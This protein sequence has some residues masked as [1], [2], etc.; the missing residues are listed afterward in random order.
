M[1]HLP[2]ALFLAA[3]VLVSPR[4][5]PDTTAPQI[6]TTPAWCGDPCQREVYEF[7]GR[8][9]EGDDLAAI[10]VSLDGT[11]VDTRVYDDGDGFEPY[12]WYQPKWADYLEQ[13]DYAVQVPVPSGVHTVTVVLTDRAG[14]RAEHSHVVEGAAP[15]D[16]VGDLRAVVRGDRVRVLFDPA[17]DNGGAVTAYRV[18]LDGRPYAT[19]RT[20]P[21]MPLPQIVVDD[22]AAGRHRLAVRAVNSAGA[23][24]PA[25][26]RV[27][28]RR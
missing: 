8:L 1:L 4:A 18:S 19:F 17:G 22:L 11:P 28:V 27:R 20:G 13:V 14:N 12:G 23:G 5:T 26:V 3:G 2:T 9:A 15:P 24:E 21:G 25:T 16:A 6:D 7:W 10:E